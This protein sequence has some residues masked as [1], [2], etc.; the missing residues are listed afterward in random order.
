MAA[1]RRARAKAKKKPG[2]YLGIP[3]TEYHSWQ[4]AASCSLLKTVRNFNA[5]QAYHNQ[6][7]PPDQTDAM[8]FGE[9]LHLAALEPDTFSDRVVCG[10]GIDRRSNANKIA[11]LK[12]EKKNK[13]KLVLKWSDFERLEAMGAAMVTHPLAYEILSMDGH[14]EASM[15]WKDPETKMLC[16][17][18]LDALGRWQKWNVI[19]DVKTTTGGLSDDELERTIGRFGYDMQ[20]AFYLDGADVLAKS[21]RRFLFVFVTKNEPHHIR[22]IELSATAL[23][24]GR[25]KYRKALDHWAGC[26]KNKVYPGYPPVVTTLGLKP[27]DEVSER[28]FD[29]EAS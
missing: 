11:H 24:E 1:K 19:V 20:A 12:F 14:R 5:K 21:D 16:K 2:I 25:Y 17:A 7:N 10:L 3:D 4:W 28:D 27:W 15:V 26:V 18:R 8:A 23:Y 22:V 13:G 29:Q 9:A 6:A